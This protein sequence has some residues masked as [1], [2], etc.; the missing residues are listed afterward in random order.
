MRAKRLIFFLVMIAIGL[1]AGLAYGWF[2]RPAQQ[3]ASTSPESLRADFRADFVLMTAEIYKKDNNL[4]AAIRR[5]ALLGDEP[6]ARLVAQALITARDVGYAPADLQTLGGL[7][8]ALTP[9][10]GQP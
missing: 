2:L 6:P 5:L 3:A 9:A 1:A 4:A 7:S 8:Q 10:G